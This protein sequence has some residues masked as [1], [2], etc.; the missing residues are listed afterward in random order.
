MCI[1]DSY[2]LH[3]DRTEQEVCDPGCTTHCK[4][5]MSQH[6]TEWKQ[7]SDRISASGGN[8]F[9]LFK[10]IAQAEAVGGRTP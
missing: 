9:D 4:Q 1:I 7:S 5:T 3:P 6:S 10:N 2:F 8:Y